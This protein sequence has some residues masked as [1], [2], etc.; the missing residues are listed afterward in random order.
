[1]KQTTSLFCFIILFLGI[2]LFSSQAQN[3]PLEGVS[4]SEKTYYCF[5]QV[6]V[7]N[8]TLVITPLREIKLPTA[9]S[10]I[11]EKKNIL[12][13]NAVNNPQFLKKVR[14]Q[15]AK[16]MQKTRLPSTYNSIIIS[17]NK[18]EVI[19]ERNLWLS[20]KENNI[21]H[22]PDFEFIQ[23]QNQTVATKKIIID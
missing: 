4:T 18:E 2:G 5:A 20:K 7:D 16:L 8:G 9:N 13:F 3:I 11:E 19:E 12:A 22:V 1:M 23:N 6:I 10:E 15:Y 17:A 14:S 21:I